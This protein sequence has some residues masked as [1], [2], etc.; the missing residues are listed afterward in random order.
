M[1][2]SRLLYVIRWLVYIPITFL[3]VY[4]IERM[5]GWLIR[6]VLAWELSLFFLFLFIMVLGGMIW[7]LF[8]MIAQ[9]I[10]YLTLQICPDKKGGGY[11][12]ASVVGIEFIFLLYSVWQMPTSYTFYTVVY[13]ILMSIMVLELGGLLISGAI[14]Q[15]NERIY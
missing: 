11:F 4:I 5:F 7:G 6:T 8:M 14:D 10:A 13:C 3:V 9:G 1:Q 2:N 12:F 15:A